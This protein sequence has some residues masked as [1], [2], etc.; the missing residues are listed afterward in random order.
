ML[1]ILLIILKLGIHIFILQLK[2]LKLIEVNIPV[3]CVRV[4]LGG[5][6]W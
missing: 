1:L 4:D 5:K 2:K 6:P 3:T